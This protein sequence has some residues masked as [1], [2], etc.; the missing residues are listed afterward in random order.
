MGKPFFSI[1]INYR[2]DHDDKDRF[3]KLLQSLIDQDCKDYELIIL[4]DG[5]DLVLCDSTKELLDKLGVSIRLTE[6]FND[7]GHSLRQIGIYSCKG[8]YVLLVNGDNLLYNVL[9]KIKEQI[10]LSGEKEVYFYRLLMVGYV[11]EDRKLLRTFDTNDSYLLIS[12]P[13]KYNVDVMSAVVSLKAWKS[14]GGWHDRTEESDYLLYRELSDKFGYE[15]VDS[16][17]IGEHW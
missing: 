1:I 6:R 7:W 12:K 3:N 13:F 15:E 17:I 16:I 2:F 5:K 11:V 8:K 14:I 10:K 4:H 9:A